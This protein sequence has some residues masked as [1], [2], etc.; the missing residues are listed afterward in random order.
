MAAAVRRTFGNYLQA[1]VN[2]TLLVFHL[3]RLFELDLPYELLRRLELLADLRVL[4]L[5]SKHLLQISNGQLRLENLYMTDRTA[6]VKPSAS[7]REWPLTREG[8]RM[9]V[10]RKR[11]GDMLWHILG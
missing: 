10:R 1:S 3:D 11:T 4:R 6:T 2:G 7:R 9:V 5:E 8:E